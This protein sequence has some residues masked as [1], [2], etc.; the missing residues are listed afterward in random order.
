MKEELYT[1]IQLV[2]P[3]QWVKNAFVF[4][5]LVFSGKFTAVQSILDAFIAFFYF[6]MAS[7]IVYIFNDLTDIKSDREHPVKSYTRP[8]ASGIINKDKAVFFMISLGL[9]LLSDLI[10][11]YKCFLVILGYIILNILYSLWLKQVVI[12]DIFCIALGFLLRVLAGGIAISVPISS[13]MFVSVLCLS[14]Y[15]GSIKRLAELRNIKEQILPRSVLQYYSESLL[16]AYAQIAQTAAIVFYGLFIVTERPKLWITMPIVIYAFFRYQY[17]T[18]CFEKGEAPS[19]II[20]RDKYLIA[21][22]VL[23]CVICLITMLL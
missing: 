21:C 19:E 17:L 23:W 14:L 3:Y 6:I 9:I 13:W 12:I 2:R 1:Y 11:D 4:A 16:A 22:I 5:P 18:T 15:L 20:F 8:L 10:I 7:S